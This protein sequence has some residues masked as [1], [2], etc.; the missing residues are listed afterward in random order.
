MKIRT[1]TAGMT[2][3]FKKLDRQI[4]GIAEFLHAAR[5]TYQKHSIEVQS[6]RLTVQSWTGLAKRYRKKQYLRMIRDLENAGLNN[7]IDFLSVGQAR[8][9]ETIRTIPDIILNTR[10]TTACAII[11]DKKS[12]FNRELI[13]S[14]A[15]TVMEISRNTVHGYGNFR[16]AGIANCPARTPF[17]PASYHQGAK[18]F[19]LGL[20]CS[21]LLHEAFSA[22][23]QSAR[24]NLHNIYSRTAKSI[25]R[26]GSEISSAHRFLFHGIDLSPAPSLTKKD[27]IV[28]AFEKIMGAPFG[29][30]GTLVVAGMITDV[31]RKLPVKKCGYSGLMLPVLEDYGLARRYGEGRIKMRDLLTISAVCGTGLDC[32]PLPGSVSARQLIAILADVATLSLKLNKPLSAR[33]LPVPGKKAGEKAR[34]KSPYLIDCVIPTLS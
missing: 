12:G 2:L 27:S 7:Q 34:F 24:A 9:P 10:R 30:S 20:E 29:S 15:E 31:L 23:A 25:S 5:Q 19:A 28:H 26:I 8:T 21:D 3:D 6:L 4:S 33:L 13:K 32:I 14:T 11:A 1:I 16:F 18:W 22:G 17:Y